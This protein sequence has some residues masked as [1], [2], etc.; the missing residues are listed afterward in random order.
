MLEV[1][2]SVQAIASKRY[3]HR[4][5]VNPYLVGD[6]CSDDGLPKR[7]ID[8]P[9]S[10]ICRV[11]FSSMGGVFTPLDGHGPFLGL[12]VCD[13][14]GDMVFGPWHF[15]VGHEQVFFDQ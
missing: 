2:A 7:T 10:C 8:S 1:A 14:G 15:P 4:G 5:G 9:E 13:R 12:V 3:P 11:P 6:P